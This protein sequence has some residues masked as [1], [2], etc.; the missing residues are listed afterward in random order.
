[1]IEMF[2]MG[3]AI[4]TRS[5]SPII[6]LNDQENRKA[7]PIWIG[8]AEASAIIK[9]LENIETPRPMTHDLINSILDTV[10]C[11]IKKIEINDLNE[12]TY[13]ATIFL[14]DKNG[15][16]YEIDSRPSDAIT[17]ALKNRAPIFVTPN[18]V[19]DGTISTDMERDQQES[20]DF[21]KFLNNIKPS[22]FKKLMKEDINLD[23][24]G[25]EENDN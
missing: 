2:I 19:M 20:E 5:G 4:D 13:Y 1:M 24:P 21:K 8:Q 9:I 6:I 23:E 17:L 3:I 16:D 12:N 18:V 25:A 15:K 7:L 14:T 11:K 10:S 22:D